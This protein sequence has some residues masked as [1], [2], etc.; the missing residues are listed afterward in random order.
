MMS[1]S[2]SPRLDGGPSCSP[3]SW[4]MVSL[5]ALADA[6]AAGGAGL[7]KD[8]DGAEDRAA[9]RGVWAVVLVGT[10]DAPV[11]VKPCLLNCLLCDPPP[12]VGTGEKRPTVAAAVGVCKSEEPE[13]RG[14]SLSEERGAA[15]AALEEEEEAAAMVSF[16]D[17]RGGVV[18]AAAAAAA[19]DEEAAAAAEAC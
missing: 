1:L 7:P 18:C 12:P 3:N 8:G 4:T 19:N 6:A 14:S 17:T 2:L 15:F 10:G 5:C 11:L 16:N 13:G 9:T